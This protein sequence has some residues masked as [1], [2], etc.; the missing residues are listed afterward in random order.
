M[1]GIYFS[2]DTGNELEPNWD[3]YFLIEKS[4]NNIFVIFAAYPTEHNDQSR[5]GHGQFPKGSQ[6]DKRECQTE[7]YFRRKPDVRIV[8]LR[9]G[10]FF[11]SFFS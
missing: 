3:I 1:G 7:Q 9:A 11:T 2:W 8:W 4:F 6:K 5:P 10:H